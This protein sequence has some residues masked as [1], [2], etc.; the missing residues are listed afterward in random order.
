MPVDPKDALPLA[1]FLFT[2]RA[3]EPVSTRSAQARSRLSKEDVAAYRDHLA[4]LGYLHIEYVPQGNRPWPDHK[5]TL[6][7][8][9][10]ALQADLRRICLD[11]FGSLDQFT[12]QESDSS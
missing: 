8:K 5:I 4:A 10:E 2:L 11:L 3:D 6:T 9:G 12:K 7:P 1:A